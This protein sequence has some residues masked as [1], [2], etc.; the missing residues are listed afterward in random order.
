MKERGRRRR[1][2]R[3]RDLSHTSLLPDNSPQHHGQTRLKPR[4]WNS[5]WASHTRLGPSICANTSLSPRVCPSRKLNGKWNWDTIRGAPI[6]EAD[7][8]TRGL[9]TVLQHLACIISPSCAWFMLTMHLSLDS[10]SCFG[11]SVATQELV[12]NTIRVLEDMVMEVCGLWIN[13][14]FLIWN[15]EIMSIS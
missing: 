8:P 5:N 12:G 14:D 9:T 6:W 7:I 11:C 2:R 3:E 1:K 10:S 13:F 15:I 4:A